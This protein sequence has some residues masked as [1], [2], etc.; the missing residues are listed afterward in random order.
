MSRGRA[1]PPLRPAARRAGPRRRLGDDACSGG[2]PRRP[3][4]SIERQI[5]EL[6]ACPLQLLPILAEDDLLAAT[7]DA[8]TAARGAHPPLLQ[9]PPAGRRAIGDD[10]VVLRAGT[11]TTTARSTCSRRGPATARWTR[12]CGDAATAAG[13]IEAPDTAV[14]DV[15]L[16]LPAAD[17][18][19]DSDALSAELAAALAAAEL[20]GAVRRVALIVSHAR[21]RHRGADV[22]AARRRRGAAVLDVASRARASRDGLRPDA[23]S[24]RTSSSAGCTR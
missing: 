11:S 4:S 13:D 6:V 9:D 3:G 2:R 10:D 18:P 14:V 24:R 5:D 8:R 15:Y 16:P 19:V 20:P 17:P 1:P 7:D 21:R 22:P 12:H 23:A